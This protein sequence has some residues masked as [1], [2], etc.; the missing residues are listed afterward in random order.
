MSLRIA[1][2]QLAP[3][4]SE[5]NLNL[6]RAWELIDT[7]LGKNAVDL[8][9]LPELAL[10]GYNFK[11]R[12]HITPVLEQKGKGFSYDFARDVSKKFNC[13]TV[14]GY[15]ELS[16][17]TIYNSAMVVSPKG[18]LIHNYRKTHLYETDETWGCSESPSG[19]TSFDLP[20]ERLGKSFKTSIG[21][22][23]DLNPYQFKAPF[24][25]YEF[26]TA[27]VKNEVELVIV[28]TAWMN[29]AWD[30]HWTKDQLNGFQQCY[31]T[32]L[33]KLEEVNVDDIPGNLLKPAPYPYSKEGKPE[34]SEYA[35]HMLESDA[36]T[37]RYWL[38]R[39]R[40]LWDCKANIVICNRSGMEDN[41]MYAGT[42]SL[43]SFLGGGMKQ[44][45][46]SVSIDMKIHGSLAMASEGVLYR[47]VPV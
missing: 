26:A 33:V 3:Q 7:S 10:T 28:P 36:N 31:R 8:V 37:G 6:K 1:A 35:Q 45:D 29:S 39:L 47:E 11:D 21:I 5:R 15:P 17:N 24:E 41:L 16:G 42:S 9:V 4:L 12:N 30:E 38:I 27:C 2:V 40:P 20:I 22:C 44:Q 32:P 43:I 13:V 23:M 34:Y 14:I 46:N 19:F 25:E 18:S